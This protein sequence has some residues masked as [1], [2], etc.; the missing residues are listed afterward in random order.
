MLHFLVV[1][2]S[3]LISREQKDSL[4]NGRGRK[5]RQPRQIPVYHLQS[6]NRPISREMK[7]VWTVELL[8]DVGGSVNF[9]FL[10]GLSVGFSLFFSHTLFSSS[11][12]LS[13]FRSLCL[14]VSD[15]LCLC[16]CVCV[17]LSLSSE[18]QWYIHLYYPKN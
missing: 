14:F 9:W 3:L 8:C 11:F 16:L 18:I 1:V 4:H 12:F 7:M 5:A 17:S 10:V 6:E 2:E 13:L 15:S